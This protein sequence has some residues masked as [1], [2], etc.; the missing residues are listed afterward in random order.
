MLISRPGNHNLKIY[1]LVAASIFGKGFGAA[2]LDRSDAKLINKRKKEDL[3]NMK[4]KDMVIAGVASTRRDPSKASK[5]GK[6]REPNAIALVGFGEQPGQFT[7]YDRSVVGAQFGSNRVDEEIR[8]FRLDAG[9]EE[10]VAL[11]I[12]GSHPPHNLQRGNGNG[13]KPSTP[14]G[15]FFESH[16]R[17]TNDELT[18]LMAKLQEL[19]SR[20]EEMSRLSRRR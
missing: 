20:F 3:N 11:M 7:W 19:S 4:I 12:R 18:S 16:G 8:D 9:Q 1:E 2:Y 14:T 10:P 5:R 13:P 17:A 6:V 15:V